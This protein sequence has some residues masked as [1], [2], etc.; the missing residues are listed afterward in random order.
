M[1]ILTLKRVITKKVVV[2]LLG[3]RSVETPRIWTRKEQKTNNRLSG[4]LS[5]AYFPA[6]DAF[7]CLI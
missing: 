1:C 4:N 5:I 3:T 2:N 7:L 6:S